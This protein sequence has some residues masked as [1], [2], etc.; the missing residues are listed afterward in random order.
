VDKGYKRDNGLNDTRNPLNLS[1]L[2]ISCYLD[3]TGHNIYFLSDY[4]CPYSGYAYYRR[5]YD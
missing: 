4:T 2:Q 1:V 5:L 3:D